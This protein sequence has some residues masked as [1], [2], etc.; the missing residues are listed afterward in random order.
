MGVLAGCNMQGFR[1]SELLEKRFLLASAPPSFLGL[2]FDVVLTGGSKPLASSGEYV[3]QFNDTTHHYSVIPVTPN[4]QAS[5]GVY[6]LNG[7]GGILAEDSVAGHLT[8]NFGFLTQT[9]G[10]GKIIRDGGG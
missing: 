7:P 3:I 6:G 9:T 4:I 10:T 5:T 2:S 1:F 8:I